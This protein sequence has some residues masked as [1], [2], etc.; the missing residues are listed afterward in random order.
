[1]VLLLLYKLA[2]GLSLEQNS[3]LLFLPN[4]WCSKSTAYGLVWKL[5]VNLGAVSRVGDF[6]DSAKS[7]KVT[8]VFM[9][10]KLCVLRNGL[11]KVVHFSIALSLSIS[12]SLHPSW[13]SWP[14]SSVW[15]V[16]PQDYPVHPHESWNSWLSLAMA[17][18][19]P[20]QMAI[21]GNMGGTLLYIPTLSMRT[22]PL[23]KSFHTH[24]M[25]M[26]CNRTSS[27]SDIPEHG[28]VGRTSCYV[29]QLISL[30]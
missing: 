24:A 22:Y 26:S 18:F 29:W 7:P 14:F 16:H 23:S 3:P 5:P 30:N 9:Q 8:S 15:N 11:S 10:G 21:S 6:G 1:M 25:L 2:S 17:C 12:I 28:H 20:S 19:L 13:H 27:P 4:S